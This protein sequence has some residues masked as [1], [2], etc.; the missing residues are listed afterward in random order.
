MSDGV[1]IEK[2]LFKTKD[3]LKQS[4]AIPSTISEQKKS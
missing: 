2:M 3:W 1:H 4:I